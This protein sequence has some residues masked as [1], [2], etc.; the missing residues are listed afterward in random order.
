ML[1]RDIVHTL[2]Y[3]VDDAYYRCQFVLNSIHTLFVKS[4]H[5]KF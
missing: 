3:Y 4:N 2:N 5:S 1:L